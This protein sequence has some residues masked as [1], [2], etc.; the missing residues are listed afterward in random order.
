MRFHEQLPSALSPNG[1]CEEVMSANGTHHFH[2]QSEKISSKDKES[3]KNLSALKGRQLRILARLSILEG[4]RLPTVGAVSAGQTEE[5]GLRNKG[6]GDVCINTH[7][8]KSSW[9]TETTGSVP[10]IKAPE[11]DTMP[12]ASN[13]TLVILLLV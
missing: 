6:D 8:V 1:A 12:S 9:R 7:T 2:D 11:T 5:H 13:G 10:K 3:K 4:G